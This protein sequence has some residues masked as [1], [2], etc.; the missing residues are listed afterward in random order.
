MDL[1]TDVSAVWIALL[2]AQRPLACRDMGEVLAEFPLTKRWTSLKQGYRR[3]Y[4]E[5]SGMPRSYL[6]SV[7][8]RCTVPAGVSVAEILEAT[9]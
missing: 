6:Y 1:Q 9:A 8:P 4:F 7:T 2:R 5:R 3:G